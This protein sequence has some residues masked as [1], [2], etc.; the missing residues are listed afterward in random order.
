M[1]PSVRPMV[2]ARTV[3][4]GVDCEGV[5]ADVRS[6]V[7]G[8][9]RAVVVDGSVGGG[10]VFTGVGPSSASTAHTATTLV[11][12]QSIDPPCIEQ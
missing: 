2:G 8:G 3:L 12:A 6:G 1:S 10:G 5:T 4:R 7:L 11:L 9:G